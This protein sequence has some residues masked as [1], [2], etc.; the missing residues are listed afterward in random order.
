MGLNL[1]VV[2]QYF[3]RN[4]REIAYLIVLIF[5]YKIFFVTYNIGVFLVIIWNYLFYNHI[6]LILFNAYPWN[7]YPS[8]TI[9]FPYFIKVW[10]NSVIIIVF[11]LWSARTLLFLRGQ[12]C[13]ESHSS[14][15]ITGIW[16]ISFFQYPTKF[17]LTKFQSMLLA[18]RARE[19]CLVA[20]NLVV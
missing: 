16:I 14:S 12:F 15:L 8:W 11:C 7:L 17:G 13:M 10:S 3:L 6:W 20:L 1:S 9:N 2:F 4:F 19:H 18:D 5:Q